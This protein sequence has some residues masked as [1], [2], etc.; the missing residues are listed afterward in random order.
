MNSSHFITDSR[1]LL[2]KDGEY[3]HKDNSDSDND[4]DEEN[5]NYSDR[6]K[7]NFYSKIID[8]CFYFPEELLKM[9]NLQP[10]SL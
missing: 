9:D 8:V 5:E 1:P 4:F 3:S 2:P 6:G 10:L 7:E